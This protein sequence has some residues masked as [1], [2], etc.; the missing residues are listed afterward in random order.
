MTNYNINYVRENKD[1]CHSKSEGRHINE[2][3]FYLLVAGIEGEF[4]FSFYLIYIY[5]ITALQITIDDKF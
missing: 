2:V 5:G 3:Y 4:F 1:A